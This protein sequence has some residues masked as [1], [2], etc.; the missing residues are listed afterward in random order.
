MDINFD[1][2][3]RPLFLMRGTDRCGKNDFEI[4]H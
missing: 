2:T 1:H 3:R 4:G